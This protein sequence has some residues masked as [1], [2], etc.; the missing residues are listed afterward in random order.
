VRPIEQPEP[1]SIAARRHCDGRPDISHIAEEE[2]YL[3]RRNI[4]VVSAQPPE[5]TPKVLP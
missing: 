1:V 4:Q 5:V 2:T 3:M